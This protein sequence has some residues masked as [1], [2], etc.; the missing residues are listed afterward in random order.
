MPLKEA[1]INSE[2]NIMNLN[3]K[4]TRYKKQEESLAFIYNSKKEVGG[5][6]NQHVSIEGDLQLDPELNIRRR[7]GKGNLGFPRERLSQKNKVNY[8]A[9][10]SLKNRKVLHIGNN[11]TR[12]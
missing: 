6:R 12:D 9:Q 10:A 11:L 3:S 1:R 8:Q 2:G 4:Q 5:K 7:G